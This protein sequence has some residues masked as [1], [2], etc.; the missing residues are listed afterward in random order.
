MPW[1]TVSNASPSALGTGLLGQYFTNSSTTYSSNR[2]FN[3]TNLFLTRIDPVI[4]F[5]WGT[6]KHR[7]IL[8]KH[9]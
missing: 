2:N 9:R 8:V 7:W 1:L 4:D 6:V 5:V 3:I